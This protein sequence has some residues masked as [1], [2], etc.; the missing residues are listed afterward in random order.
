LTSATDTGVAQET[1]VTPTPVPL[2]NDHPDLSGLV[3]V[4]DPGHQA[5]TDSD[6]ETLAPDS[7]IVKPRCTSG[8]VGVSTNAR[9]YEITLEV[10]LIAK[11]Y[12]EECG[13][14]VIITRDTNDIDLSNQERANLAVAANPDIYIRL[15]ADASPESETSG[16][17]VFI[18]EDGSFVAEDTSLADQLGAIVAGNQG[19]NYLGTFATDAYTGLNYASSIRSFQL[20]MGYISN[21]D[22]EKRLTDSESQYELAVSIA[23]FCALIK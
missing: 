17:R 1:S 8:A 14:D 10:G 18:P 15:H 22:D 12:L 9:E 16:V 13:A 20:V 4:I 5:E 2:K 11:S 23:D 21:S 6:T 3:I 7:T 19:V